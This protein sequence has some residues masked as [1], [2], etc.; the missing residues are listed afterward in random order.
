MLFNSHQG[1]HHQL[2]MGEKLTAEQVRNEAVA[3]MGS[4]PRE[5]Y[6]SLSDQVL[7]LRTK[8]FCLDNAVRLD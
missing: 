7:Y 2:G 5:V 3:A 8:P 1:D 6:H 4:E